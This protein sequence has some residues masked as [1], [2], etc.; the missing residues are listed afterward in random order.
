M[1][2]HRIT[3]SEMRDDH[4]S[5]DESIC[6]AVFRSGTLSPSHSCT[7]SSTVDVGEK[8]SHTDIYNEEQQQQLLAGASK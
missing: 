7:H 5:K 8:M 1:K 6:Q 2:L 4:R 3:I